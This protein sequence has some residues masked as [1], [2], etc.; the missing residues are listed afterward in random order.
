M[1]CGKMWGTP[2]EEREAY[3][4]LLRISIYDGTMETVKYVRV[5]IWCTLVWNVGLA[6]IHFLV[7]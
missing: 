1:L 7:I 5:N 2:F 4:N 3:E 6:E